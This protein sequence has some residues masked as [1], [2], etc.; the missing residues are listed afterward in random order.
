M[1]LPAAAQKFVQALAEGKLF[2]LPALQS[3]SSLAYK[4]MRTPFTKLPSAEGKAGTGAAVSV[5]VIAIERRSEA[6]EA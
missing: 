6:L 4:V 5:E 1:G 2:A 3:H